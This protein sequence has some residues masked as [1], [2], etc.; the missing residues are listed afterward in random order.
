MDLLSEEEVSCI[1]GVYGSGVFQNLLTTPI[2][3]AASD[4]A[5]ATPLFQCLTAENVVLLGIAFLDAQAG[6]WD[7]ESRSCITEIGLGH[8]DAV[9]VRLGLQLG[10]EP[11]DPAETLAYNVQIYECLTDDEKKAFTVALW[12]GLD[13]NALATGADILGLL[14]EAEASCVEDGLSEEDFATMLGA[15]PLQATSIGATVSHCIDPETN[16][17]IFA[18]GIQWIMGGMTDNSLSC[19]EDFGRDNPEFIALMSLGLEGIQAV[20]AAQF[21]EIIAVGNEQYFCMTPDELLRV[22]QAATAAM[23]AQ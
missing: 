20:P 13:N 22:Q 23:Q 14:S 19:L 6:G 9:F 2:L 18:N 5:A 12:T 21:L 16:L 3:A 1:E 7:D 8:P 15:Q 4:P 11:I 10:P 17:K